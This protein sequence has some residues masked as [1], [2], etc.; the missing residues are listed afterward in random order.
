MGRA[1]GFAG[2]GTG[3]QHVLTVFT[4]AGVEGILEIKG[5]GDFG[6]F[7]HGELFRGTEL[8]PQLQG[9]G[10][11]VLHALGAGYAFGLVHHRHIVGADGV[12]GAEHQ[13]GPKTEAGTGA[14]VADG[15]GI[16]GFFN[17]R[18][19]V[20]ETVFFGPE[21]DFHRL[22]PGYLPGAAGPDI[23]LGPFA[24]LDAH[25]LVQ[26]TAAV[27]NAGAGGTAGTGRDGENI[28]LVQI[29]GQPL[30]RAHI[31]D[32]FQGTLHRNYPHQ[33]VAVRQDGTHGLHSQTGIL[34]K[35]TA[36][37][38]MGF[39]QFNVV[40]HHLQNAGCEDLHEVHILAVRL[41]VGAAEHA[42]IDQIVQRGHNLI[43]GLAHLFRQP[44]GGAF[45]PKPCRNGQIRFIVADNVAEAVVLRSVF[46]N[47]V[48]YT[49]YSADH[50][51]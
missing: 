23:V 33:A 35:S 14:A 40:D 4:V 5:V 3:R 39:H 1:G 28:I 49:G 44:T 30:I 51:T 27:V 37:L 20:H 42:V 26:V 7:R 31:R 25:F 12:P 50:V 47:F 10:G 11:T 43:H 16:A 48:D 22:F 36:D 2:C 38:G 32:I 15:G 45:L 6:V 19:V 41:A 13:P 17:V 34:L 29:V 24:H 9:V 21:N 46:V 18:D 8:L